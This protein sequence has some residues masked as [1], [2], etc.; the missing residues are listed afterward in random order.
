MRSDT[1]AKTGNRLEEGRI[2]VMGNLKSRI[3]DLRVICSERLG[4]SVR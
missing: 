1:Y 3:L 2:D 4:S